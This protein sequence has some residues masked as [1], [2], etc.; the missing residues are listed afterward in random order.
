V[1][2]LAQQRWPKKLLINAFIR[3]Y[4]V[5]MSESLIAEHGD[6]KN[7]N[8]FFTRELKPGARPIAADSGAIVCPADGAVS[9]AGKLADNR[10]LQ[11]KAR[12]YS[13]RDLL[14]GDSRLAEMFRDGTFVTIYLSPRDYHRVHMPLSGRLQK[15]IYVPGK[16]FSVNQVTTASVANLFARNERVICL[17]ET[18]IGPMA[19]IMVGAMIVASIETVWSG[20][21]CPAAERSR[22]H[23]TDY[24][25]ISPP[26]TLTT[27]AEM[28]RFKLGSTA[29]VLFGRGA[30]EL[31]TMLATNSSVRM[32]QL[33]GICNL[34]AKPGQK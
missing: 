15:M 18:E 7:F 33:L 1:G 20:Q 34:K 14:G 4:R 28:G 11:A 17:F 16:L 19:V 12:F 26:I 3:R 6:F 22:V 23:T 31:N 10:L 32:G 13:V 2:K 25:N 5:D 27:G 24:S 21:V 8:A 30:M 9:Q 29:I